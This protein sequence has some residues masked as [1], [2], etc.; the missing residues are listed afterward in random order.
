M[1]IEQTDRRVTEI[2]SQDV[3]FIEDDFPTRGEVD[4]SLKLYKTLDQEEGM[5]G[6]KYCLLDP[7]LLMFV[8]LLAALITN[9]LY[10][11]WYL[12]LCRS[13][14][15]TWRAKGKNVDLK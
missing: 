11:F 15:Q 6:V 7:P 9:I 8:R 5:I 3:D 2:E 12:V 14:Q 4:R 1:L 13:L 10:S